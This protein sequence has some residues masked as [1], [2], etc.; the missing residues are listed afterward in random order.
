[1]CEIEHSTSLLKG[2]T[3]MFVLASFIFIIASLILKNDT[4]LQSAGLF[5]I[6][7]AIEV[8]SSNFTNKKEKA[9]T[10]TKQ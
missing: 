6:A 2:E 8:L 5:A 1:M 3:I 9:K 7:G 4:M 10:E